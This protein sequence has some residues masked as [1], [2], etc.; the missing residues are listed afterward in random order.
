MDSMSLEQQLSQYSLLSL[1]SDLQKQ[2]Q[3]LPQNI[4]LIQLPP[5]TVNSASSPPQTSLSSQSPTATSAPVNSVSI[6]RP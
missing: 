3:T 2:Q 1:L 6:T 5:I 4:R